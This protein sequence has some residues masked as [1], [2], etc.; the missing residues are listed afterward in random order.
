M[1]YQTY[2]NEETTNI[3][4]VDDSS[5]L[6]QIWIDNGNMSEDISIAKTPFLIT[7]L[8]VNLSSGDSHQ[9]RILV[10]DETSL[11]NDKEFV[12]WLNILELNE[13]LREKINDRVNVAFRTRIKLFYRPISI[14]ESTTEELNEKLTFKLID[15]KKRIKIENSTPLYRTFLY[16][17]NKNKDKN[18]INGD[19]MVAPFSYI[20][21][22]INESFEIGDKINY[23]LINDSGLETKG[24]SIIK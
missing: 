5:V 6:L 8:M 4:S 21:W 16:A 2:F 19:D 3:K 24:E 20:E 22:N 13:K 17:S 1:V 12:F 11:P 23:I 18:I 10:V 14:S 9:I 15:N 7:E